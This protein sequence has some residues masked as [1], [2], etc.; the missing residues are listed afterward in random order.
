MRW[1]VA[2]LVGLLVLLQYKLWL[3][4]GGIGEV[5]RIRQAVA[6]QERTNAELEERNEALRGEVKDL[7]QGLEAI[8]ERARS[9]LGMVKDG[10]IFYQVVE[11]H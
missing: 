4:D 11:E 1:L 6:R 8:E 10:E 2:I 3:G 7:K 9:E 5:R